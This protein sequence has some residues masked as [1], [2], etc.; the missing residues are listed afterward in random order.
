MVAGGNISHAAV[1]PT[2]YLFSLPFI[3]SLCC[4]ISTPI[5][6]SPLL[7]YDSASHIFFLPRDT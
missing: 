5:Y 7:N 2:F 1:I 4:F 6:L 3:F